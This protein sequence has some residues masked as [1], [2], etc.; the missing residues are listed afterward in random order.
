MFNLFKKIKKDAGTA[1]PFPVTTDIHSHILPGID[2]GSPDIATSL[3]LVKGL[4]DLGYRKL[5]ATPHV[6]GDFYR[7]NPVI[8]NKQLEILKNACAEA[9]INI[10]LSAAAEYMLDDYFLEILK[11][12]EVLPVDNNHILTELPYSVV[13][14]NVNEIVFEIITA[15]YKPILAHPERYFYYHRD[16]DEYFRLKELGFALQVNL[17]SITGY[18]GASVAKG[19]KFIFENGLADFVGTDMHHVRHLEALSNRETN[20][21]LNKYLGDKEYNKFE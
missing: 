16:F 3:K 4:Y 15:G 7:N 21:I 8:I 2:D 9:G 12:K 1:L 14:M 13:P 5:V 20:I 18:Y 17:L 11:K 6:I 19:A 10:E